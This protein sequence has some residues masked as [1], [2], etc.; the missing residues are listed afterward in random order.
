MPLRLDYAICRHWVPYYA[1]WALL[2]PV[3]FP[4]FIHWGPEGHV[5][6][7][8]ILVYSPSYK[9]DVLHVWHVPL[10]SCTESAVC[11]GCLPSL[12]DACRSPS[13]SVSLGSHLLGTCPSV[14]FHSRSL[15][16]SLNNLF[17][18]ANLWSHIIRTKL[19]SHRTSMNAVHFPSYRKQVLVAQHACG[20]APLCLNLY[21]LCS[22]WSAPDPGHTFYQT[23]LTIWN[24]SAT[25]SSW[26]F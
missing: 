10:K 15:F 8:N 23:S 13:K 14:P 9:T 24:P 18:L 16:V 20:C 12:S 3:S 1:L 17:V 22:S 6:F 21:S 7:D 26:L 25:L 5:Y 4:E 11:Q 2:C 19:F